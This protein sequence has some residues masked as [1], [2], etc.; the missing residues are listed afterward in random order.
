MIARACG[1]DHWERLETEYGA[2]RVVVQES[3]QATVAQA[4]T[5]DG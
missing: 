4:M 1:H 2:A 3:W 5:A